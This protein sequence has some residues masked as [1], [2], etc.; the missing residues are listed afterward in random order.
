MTWHNQWA[1]A[2]SLS[3]DDYGLPMGCDISMS[4][5]MHQYPTRDEILCGAGFD[6]SKFLTK[7][8]SGTFQAGDFDVLLSHENECVQGLI[9]ANRAYNQRA[10][11]DAE[12]A[13]NPVSP[14]T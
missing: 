4:C 10:I 11:R 8:Y 1:I 13:K 3:D 12:R 9:E 6:S 2:P 7:G 5:L 14:P